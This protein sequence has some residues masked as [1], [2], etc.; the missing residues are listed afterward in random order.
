MYNIGILSTQTQVFQI[1]QKLLSICGLRVCYSTRWEFNTV[2][3]RSRS[4]QT[5]MPFHWSPLLHY[6]ASKVTSALPYT[7]TCYLFRS[8]N[9]PAVLFPCISP[10]HLLAPVTM[11][12]LHAF[13]FRLVITYC[14]HLFLCSPHTRHYFSQSFFTHTILMSKPFQ[15]LPIHSSAHIFSHT[16]FAPHF[17]FLHLAILVIPYILR[18]Y[19]ISITSS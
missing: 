15:N 4:T 12:A 16:N 17:S 10:S 6:F 11:D 18:K 2:R 3:L 1:I 19:F 5:P 8:Q 7:F 9:S 13:W 14:F